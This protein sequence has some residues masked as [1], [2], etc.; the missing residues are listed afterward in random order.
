MGLFLSMKFIKFDF[1][2]NYDIILLLT[3]N[4]FCKGKVNLMFLKRVIS[5]CITFTL[6]L[7]PVFSF[8]QEN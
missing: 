4:F 2:K 6:L 5:F 3:Y 8:S 7:Y 1:L